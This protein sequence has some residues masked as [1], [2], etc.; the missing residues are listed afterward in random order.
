MSTIIKRLPTTNAA[1]SGLPVIAPTAGELRM[2]NSSSLQRWWRAS[3][4]FSPAGWECM[5]SGAVLTPAFA[6]KLP[7]KTE[8]AAYND[9]PALVFATGSTINGTLSAA[10]VLE[11]GSSLTMV[12]VGRAGPSDSAFLL[13]DG[14]NSGGTYLQHLSTGVV[15][16]N[17]SGQSGITVSGYPRVYAD[18]INIFVASFDESLAQNQLRLNRGAG[19]WTSATGAITTGVVN[20]R[21]TV[22][23]RGTPPS[24]GGT[25]DGTVDGGDIAE[26]LI[27]NE[28][29]HVNTT[30]RDVVEAYL[31][32]KYG[33][34]AV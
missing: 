16:M 9:N 31:G 20:T 29:L 5:K 33:I 15:G 19:V 24:S 12:L 3:S 17:I 23:A 13:G 32:T 30:L 4:G 27:F 8:L 11:A 10:S 2:F 14:L 6:S 28:A 21:L 22:G 26:V 1:S 7:T 34:A 18:G 25:V